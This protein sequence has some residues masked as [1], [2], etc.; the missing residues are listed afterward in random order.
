MVN[1][2]IFFYIML[3]TVNATSGA[4]WFCWWLCSLVAN[5]RKSLIR[6]NRVKKISTEPDAVIK[7]ATSGSRAIGS[8]PLACRLHCW[9][10]NLGII[11]SEQEQPLLGYLSTLSCLSKTRLQRY[12]C[13]T[14]SIF[15]H[16]YIGKFFSFSSELGVYLQQRFFFSFG[17]AIAVLR[18]WRCVGAILDRKQHFWHIEKACGFQTLQ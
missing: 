18:S 16:I 9:T 14:W 2:W 3:L 11:G 6:N 5:Y 10:M 8:P 15:A 17:S 7:R 13:F 12:I 4:A 1:V